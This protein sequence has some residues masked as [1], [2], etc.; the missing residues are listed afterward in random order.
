[1]SI[2]LDRTLHPAACG[3]AADRPRA[4]RGASV[5]PRAA[6]QG[7]PLARTFGRAL[8]SL[9][10]AY[11]PIVRCSDRRVIAH[12]ALVRS[13]EPSLGD[14][15]ALF[16]AADRLGQRVRLGREIRALL[17]GDLVDIPGDVYMNLNADDLLVAEVY[18]RRGRLAEL[19]PRLVLEITEQAPL[20]LIPDV[21][22]RITRLRD[23][24]FRLAVDDFGAGY[25][26]HLNLAILEPDVVKLDMSLIRR[27]DCDIG[28]RDAVR[29]MTRLCRK[30]RS[31]V[32]AEGVETCGERDA[33]VALGC[34]ALQG[35][36]LARPARR[37][38]SVAW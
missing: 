31:L 37:P 23:L 22:G 15:L 26:G 36:L 3:P 9:W 5:A 21:S 7:A 28:R 20:D 14:P 4:Q 33:L 24:G 38:A 12:E 16:Q 29:S 13:D 25:S 19:A 27:V 11:Q 34:D 8:S 6:A 2:K 1:M 35:F 18:D 32:V 17:V 10:M 30:L